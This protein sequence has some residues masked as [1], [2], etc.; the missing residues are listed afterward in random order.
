MV[1]Q[2]HNVDKKCLC[3]EAAFLFIMIIELQGRILSIW[4]VFEV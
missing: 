2:I 1:D 3:G 4:C